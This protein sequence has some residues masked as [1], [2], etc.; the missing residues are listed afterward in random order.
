M[1]DLLLK[2]AGSHIHCRGSSRAGKVSMT[3]PPNAGR[4][5]KKS[6]RKGGS[7][8]GSRDFKLSYL[9]RAVCLRPKVNKVLV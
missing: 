8:R 4:E 7:Y 3:P 5:M 9:E 1:R 6:D 2:M